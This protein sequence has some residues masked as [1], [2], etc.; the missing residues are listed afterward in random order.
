MKNK[1]RKKKKQKKNKRKT[2]SKHLLFVSRNE[3]K[4]I[5]FV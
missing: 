5:N 3:K 4:F 1:N 2:R